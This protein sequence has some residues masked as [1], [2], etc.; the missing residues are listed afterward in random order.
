MTRNEDRLA[1]IEAAL[2]PLAATLLWLEEALPFPSP[3]AYVAWLLEQPGLAGPL[4]RVPAQAVANAARVHRGEPWGAVFDAC[5]VAE[6]D[7]VSLVTLVL[8]LNAEAQRAIEI[9]KLRLGWL[10]AE[11]RVLLLESKPDDRRSPSPGRTRGSSSSD[12]WNAWVGKVASHL[13]EIYALEAARLQLE[14][15]HLAG[16]ATLF[17]G[18]ATAVE[19]LRVA[20]ECLAEAGLDDLEL[21]SSRTLARRLTAELNVDTLR[22]AG[23]SQAPGRAAEVLA[24]VRV[25]ALSI[26]G[27]LHAARAVAWELI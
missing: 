25:E 9:G 15:E 7:A 12:G 1:S 17:A 3:A 4:D 18:V 11:W 10:V 14:R 13:T 6:R 19:E 8:E 2:P 16:H 26:T 22:A 23:R 24:L 20:S 5:R 21:R 27:D